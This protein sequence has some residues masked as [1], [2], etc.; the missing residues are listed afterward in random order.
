M[1]FA[2]LYKPT[3]VPSRN[4]RLMIDSNETLTVKVM[5]F[6][7]LS[8]SVIFEGVHGIRSL[9]TLD[10]MSYSPFV[11]QANKREFGRRI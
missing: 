9:V 11:S 1:K 2:Y 3:A 5:P 6:V 4:V 8:V 7:F 10:V